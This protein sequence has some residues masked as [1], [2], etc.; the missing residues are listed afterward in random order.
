[1]ASFME[2][3]FDGLTSETSILQ[4]PRSPRS[5]KMAESRGNVAV[6][7]KPKPMNIDL[8]PMDDLSEYEAVAKEL[9]F[10]PP[11]LVQRK[12]EI[13][14]REVIEFL[15]DHGMPIYN[16]KQVHDYMS[17]LAEKEG[18]FFAW[19]KLGDQTGY[20]RPPMISTAQHGTIVYGGTYQHA[21]PIDMLKRAAEIKKRFGDEV[22]FY[23][24]D[25]AVVDPDPFI[26]VKRGSCSGIV[27]GVW[28]EPG[29]KP[30]AK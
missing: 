5:P 18:K 16:N 2:N 3:F 26:M 17:K 13:A 14:R 9:G 7:D 20:S 24:S 23:V 8:A 28:N 11:Q 15:L 29:F 25:Y 12:L 6:L 21:V 27:F 4:R 30:E 22:E 19:V 1:M 10:D